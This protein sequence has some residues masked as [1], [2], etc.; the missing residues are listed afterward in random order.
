MHMFTHLTSDFFLLRLILWL[1]LS[2]TFILSFSFCFFTLLCLFFFSHFT[3]NA[4]GCLCILRRSLVLGLNVS[5]IEFLLR[6]FIFSSLVHRLLSLSLTH[7]H[8]FGF[9][10]RGLFRSCRYSL[11][12]NF[13]VNN[14]GGS[15]WKRAR[16]QSNF[17]NRL[18]LYTE[19]IKLKYL[20]NGSYSVKR[21]SLSMNIITALGR[22]DASF[23]YHSP[24]LNQLN[25]GLNLWEVLFK[26]F[27]WGLDGPLIHTCFCDHRHFQ[28][29]QLI[30]S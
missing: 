24:T 6:I 22:V 18:Q 13:P 30:L 9:S 16:C 29:D 15:L 8:L 23:V 17:F 7:T 2:F 4:R 5:F 10:Q 14:H 12:T 11:R 28:S 21:H 26:R 20:C 27:V 19:S 1:S 3:H 25:W